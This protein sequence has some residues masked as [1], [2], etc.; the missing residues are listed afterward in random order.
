MAR[1]SSRYRILKKTVRTTYDLHFKLIAKETDKTRPQKSAYIATYRGLMV[2][3]E[4]NPARA[5]EK[6]ITR[7]KTIYKDTVVEMY[8]Y[9]T[10][11]EA[12]LRNIVMNFVKNL[13]NGKLKEWYY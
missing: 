5:E 4:T 11:T 7:L 1:K 9:V 8:R 2:Y 3:V 12:Q 10:Y 13:K 6:G